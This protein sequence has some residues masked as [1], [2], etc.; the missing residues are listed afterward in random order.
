MKYSNHV[1]CFLDF[2]MVTL[3]QEHSSYQ[4]DFLKT[5]VFSRFLTSKVSARLSL[6]H[7]SSS[8]KSHLS[9]CAECVSLLRL[10]PGYLLNACC[11]PSAFLSAAVTKTKAVLCFGHSRPRHRSL[12]FLSSRKFHNCK[13]FHPGDFRDSSARM[14]RSAQN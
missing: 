11:I 2:E 6:S 8:S 12:V 13:F 5:W 10:F 14:G 1:C 4:G 9:L 3:G 7:L